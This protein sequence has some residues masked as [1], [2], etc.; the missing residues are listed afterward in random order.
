MKAWPPKVD[1]CEIECHKKIICNSL[2]PTGDILAQILL[3]TA[4]SFT[5]I[6]RFIFVRKSPIHISSFPPS[7][8]LLFMC[9]PYTFV[10]MVI[11]YLLL[12]PR[13]VKASGFGEWSG[14]SPTPTLDLFPRDLKWK[15]PLSKRTLRS[16][17]HLS[18]K[19]RD[20]FWL[21]R[22]ALIRAFQKATLTRDLGATS[23]E[24]FGYCKRGL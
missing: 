5:Q 19:R 2:P 20:K 13:C 17:Y 3:Q 18:K 10:W 14:H 11:T 12:W 4:E 6:E 15:P 1:L 22:L 24:H 8:C 16:H 23:L 7:M 9:S 21:Q